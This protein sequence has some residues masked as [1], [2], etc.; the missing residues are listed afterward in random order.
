[1][2]QRNP[3]GMILS[4][5][6]VLLIFSSIAASASD[7][8]INDP[9]GSVLPAES[10]I[11]AKAAAELKITVSADRV[12]A[13]TSPRSTPILVSAALTRGGDPVPDGTVVNF[14]IS[15][16][17]GTL[18]GAT[19][20]VNGIATVRLASTTV[21]TVIVS[22]S[23][24]SV[25]ADINA[26]FLAQPVQAIV[27]V[28]SVG[29]LASGTLIGGILASVSYPANGFAITTDSVFP[30]GVAGNATTT[31]AVNVE[32]AGQVILALFD[33]NG[34]R[35]GEFATLVFKIADGFLPINGNVVVT[36]DASVV[37]AVSN[38][39]IPGASVVVQSITYR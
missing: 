9:G 7:P 14:A 17:S 35:T 22:A 30:S 39:A 21:G 27:K 8:P 38:T 2:K 15:S 4:V 23:S 16:G 19:T 20:T 28:G 26:L 18:S 36:P 31:L 37:A 25:S 11:S 12:T 5:L 24:G 13:T 3:I 29:T 1:M 34:I 6:A 33:V 32:T 10:D